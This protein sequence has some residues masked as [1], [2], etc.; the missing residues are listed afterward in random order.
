MYALFRDVL[1][2]RDGTATSNAGGCPTGGRRLDYIFVSGGLSVRN[3]RVPRLSDE[4]NP[5]DHCPVIAD[6]GPSGPV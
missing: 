6:L 5:S 3:A 1:G 4:A 2:R